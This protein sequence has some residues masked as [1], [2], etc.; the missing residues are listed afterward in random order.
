MS[1]S[2]MRERDSRINQLPMDEPTIF[3]KQISSS[4]DLSSHF[5]ACIRHTVQLSAR[6]VSRQSSSQQLSEP[7]YGM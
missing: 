2:Q 1:Y 7:L 3:S 6:N 4:I 5:Q